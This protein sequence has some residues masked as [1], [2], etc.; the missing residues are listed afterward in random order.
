MQKK[1]AV[2]IHG[3]N[4]QHAEVGTKEAGALYPYVMWMGQLFV[5]WEQGDEHVKGY[6]VPAYMRADFYR[7]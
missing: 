2:L 7:V 1:I 6:R 5:R 4:R 3:D